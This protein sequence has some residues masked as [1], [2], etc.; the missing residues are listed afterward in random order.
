[1]IFEIIGGPT[2]YKSVAM[3]AP[4]FHCSASRNSP[5]FAVPKHPC[6]QEGCS[7]RHTSAVTGGKPSPSV[8][9]N[10]NGAMPKQIPK[11]STQARSQNSQSHDT[12]TLTRKMTPSSATNASKERPHRQGSLH[13]LEACRSSVSSLEYVVWHRR[14]IESGNGQCAPFGT[15]DVRCS[16]GCCCSFGF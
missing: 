7:I 9:D 3:K 13:L 16:S 4:F 6:Q 11:T 8:K 10:T 2:T 15:F 1:V 14:E 12:E 5:G